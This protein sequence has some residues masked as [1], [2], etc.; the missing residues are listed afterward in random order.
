MKLIN[1]SL[2]LILCLSLSVPAWTQIDL[3]KK[4]KQKTEK[5]TEEEA[6]KKIDESLDKLFGKKK[7]LSADCFRKGNE[8]MVKMS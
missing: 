5:R 2:M 4:A 8:A 6:D 1:K 7:K 3:L